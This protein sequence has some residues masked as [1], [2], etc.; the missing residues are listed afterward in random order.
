MYTYLLINILSISI[1]LIASFDKRL[2]FYKKW[3]Y[4]F[5]GIFFTLAFFIAWDVLYTHWGIWGFNSRYLTGIQ[6]INLPLEEWLFF[7][8]IPY[9][10]VFTYEALNYIVKRDY[11]GRWQK[12]ISMALVMIFFVVAILHY[13]RLYTSITFG[14]TALFITFVQ[15][16]RKSSWLGRF[17]FSYLFILIPFFIVN[18]ILT[19]SFIDE[20]VVFY[21]DSMNLGIRIFTIPI[22]DSVYG[23]L[24]ILMNVTFYEWFKAR[25]Y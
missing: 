4:L 14:L 9:A 21:D 2:E 22:E 11:L 12:Q 17:Y 25:N 3:K 5:P 8:T 1:P 13:N 15:F 18:G 23:L 19:G 20:E 16:V 24:L 6:V 7:I 10:C